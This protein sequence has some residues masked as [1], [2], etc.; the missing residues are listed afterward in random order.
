[1][2]LLRFTWVV[3]VLL[4]LVLIGAGIYMTSMGYAARDRVRDALVAEQ[5]TTT[6]DSAIPGV[7]VDSAATARAQS[8]VI[9]KHTLERT[10]GKTYAQMDREDER[11]GLYV[12][13]V[14][15]RT[16]LNQAEM[17]FKLTDLVVGL[18]Y[19]VILVGAGNIATGAAIARRS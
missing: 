7:L 12:Q 1:M 18:G 10:E 5:V 3:P 9:Q 4:G 2:K 11:R 14:T 17:A 19:I 15:L 13:A 8:E 16:A 6:D